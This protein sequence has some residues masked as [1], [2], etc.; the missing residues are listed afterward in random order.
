M[1][2]CIPKSP[3]ATG[4]ATEGKKNKNRFSVTDDNPEQRMG[5]AT[6]SLDVNIDFLVR[7]KQKLSGSLN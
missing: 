2:G 5:L 3:A 7:R 1:V 4:Y 6:T